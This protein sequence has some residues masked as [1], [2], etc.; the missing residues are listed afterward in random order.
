MFGITA[1]ERQFENALDDFGSE[2]EIP[3]LY[4]SI[5]ETVNDRAVEDD[6]VHQMLN[7]HAGFWCLTVNALFE[8]SLVSLH[9]LFD[10]DS[11]RNAARLLTLAEEHIDIFTRPQLARRIQNEHNIEDASDWVRAAY[12]PSLDDFRRLREEVESRWK[13][14]KDIYRPI[15][16][17][18]IAHRVLTDAE[19]LQLFS[20]TNRTQLQEVCVFFVALHAALSRLYRRGEP[21]QIRASAKTR[22]AHGQPNRRRAERPQGKAV[23]IAAIYARKS[24]D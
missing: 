13:I 16:C 8:S 24:T 3:R 14:Y 9:R 17:R 20:R 18:V 4:L 10:S 15:R 12:E 11:K 23:M 1:I 6:V 19:S 22:P 2:A 7:Q 21:I 5:Y